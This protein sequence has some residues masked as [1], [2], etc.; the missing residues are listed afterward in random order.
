MSWNF[1]KTLALCWWILPAPLS[2]KQ[3]FVKIF[4]LFICFLEQ[5]EFKLPNTFTKHAALIAESDFYCFQEMKD[6]LET[7]CKKNS[8]GIT[9]ATQHATYSYV[10]YIAGD[11][12]VLYDVYMNEEEKQSFLSNNMTIAQINNLKLRLQHDRFRCR[13]P[14][15]HVNENSNDDMKVI[16]MET[17]SRSWMNFRFTKSQ[18]KVL[19]RMKKL[20]FCNWNIHVFISSF[21]I[22]LPFTWIISGT[23]QQFCIRW[24]HQ[25][26]RCWS[27]GDI[28]QNWFKES[29][30]HL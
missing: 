15:Q 12:S 30:G 24:K 4:H 19:M 7:E 16:L 17:F 21:R 5:N 9:F 6:W 14:S 26:A 25:N 11:T 22:D 8:A 20:K 18:E 28:V 10:L 23:Q 1:L 13:Y 2:G 3:L 27:K 29:Y